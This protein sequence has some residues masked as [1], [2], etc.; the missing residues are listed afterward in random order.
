MDAP[1]YAGLEDFFNILSKS[2][3]TGV[4]TILKS[5]DYRTVKVIVELL[6]NILKGVLPI[7]KQQVKKFRVYKPII[8]RLISTKSNLKNKKK[9][10]SENAA[11][12]K[13]AVKVL[14]DYI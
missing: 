11:L 13:L 6:L 8:N 10:L 14:I 12:V 9:L 3:V 2:S 1:I 4:K 7:S 5:T